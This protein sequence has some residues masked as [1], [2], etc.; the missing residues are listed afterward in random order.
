MLVETR[1]Q[2]D[3]IARLVAIIELINEDMVPGVLA[4]ARRAG[5]A[6]YVG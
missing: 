3:E 2:L 6:E 1:Q 5:Q 4:R